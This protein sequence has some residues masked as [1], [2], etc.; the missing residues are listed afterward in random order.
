MFTVAGSWPVATTQSMLYV[1]SYTDQAKHLRALTL[2]LSRDRPRRI[3]ACNIIQLIIVYSNYNI[4]A[5]Q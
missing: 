3:I 2:L 5:K 4:I 1:K